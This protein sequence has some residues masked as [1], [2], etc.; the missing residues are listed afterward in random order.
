MAAVADME[1]HVTVPDSSIPKG[2]KKMRFSFANVTKE[3]MHDLTISTYSEG[4]SVSLILL[5]ITLEDPPDIR[6]VT[7]SKT[8]ADGATT[9]VSTYDGGDTTQVDLQLDPPVEDDEEFTVDIEFD[10]AF[11][12]GEWLEFSPSGEGGVGLALAS[13]D[14]PMMG[15]SGLL[16]SELGNP[17]VAQRLAGLAQLTDSGL[18]T[19][20][21]AAALGSVVAGL[22]VATRLDRLEAAMAR[23]TAREP[24]P[25]GGV[26]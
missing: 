23:L 26:A 16:A 17:A 6:K 12:P 14:A 13:L 21:D 7:V 8:D 22:A 19:P 18:V 5:E 25:G 10:E 11:V 1:G 4:Y 9:V 2:K 3:S 15:R 24:G 20:S